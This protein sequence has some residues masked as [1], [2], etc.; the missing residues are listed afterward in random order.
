[1]EWFDR[2]PATESEEAKTLKKT[3]VTSRRAY[4]VI[5]ELPEAELPQG[6]V[7]ESIHLVGEFSDWDLDAMPM[8]R[9]RDGTFRLTLEMEPGQTAQFRYL[10]NG[11]QWYN[12][13][14]A[15]A[16]V[17]NAFGADNCV[18]VTPSTPET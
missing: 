4:R 18:V 8:T 12:D 14:H 15:D 11:D 17:L 5:F 1:M 2:D 9:D 3:Y 16:Y 10:L 6:M 13:W 7:I